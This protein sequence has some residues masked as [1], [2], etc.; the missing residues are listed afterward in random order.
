MKGYLSRHDFA[1]SYRAE[2]IRRVGSAAT[3]ARRAMQRTPQRPR[4]R[5]LLPI[6]DA[7]AWLVSVAMFAILR[8]DG[9]LGAVP[10]QSV[11]IA[12]ALLAAV[13]IAIAIGL[14][15]YDGRHA[16]G[17][18]DESLLL[19]LICAF[20]GLSATGILAFSTSRPV[21]L[22]LPLPATATA[23][24][25]IVGARVG[26]RLYRDRNRHADDDHRT[27]IVGAG[28]AGIQL[29]KSLLVDRRSSYDPICFVDDNPRKRHFRVGSVRVEGTL[30]DLPRLLEER[31]ID[32]IIIAA[33]SAGPALIRRVSAIAAEAGTKA[34]ALPTLSELA[35]RDDIGVSDLRDLEL[36]DFLRRE[37]VQTDLCQVSALLRGKRVLVTGAGGSIGS[38]LCRQIAQ[39]SPAQLYMLDRDES[40][41]HALQL[42]LDGR[43]LLQ[44]PG[45]VLADIRDYERIEQ[46]FTTHK[47]HVVFHA[48]AL[49]HLTMLQRYPEE[50][51][52]TNVIGTDNVLRA[53]RTSGAEIFVNISTDKAADPTSV[54]GDTKRAAERLTAA[55]AH[56][57]GRRYLSVRFGNVLGSRGS[58]LTAFAEQIRQGGPVTVTHPDVTRFF[59]TVQEAVQLV[60][61]AAALGKPADTLI[62]DMGAPVRILDVAHQMIAMSGR[63]VEIEFTGLRP[64]EKLHEDLEGS[65][66]LLV[67]TD[68][69]LI[70]RTRVEPL[71]PAVVDRI[72]ISSTGTLALDLAEASVSLPEQARGVPGLAP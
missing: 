72:A 35:G 15:L 30:D 27:V 10:W 41:L 1:R 23:I 62:L 66:E 36:S 6:F 61:Q 46:I 5:W 67:G 51:L 59:M 64:G 9:D 32:R 24:L 54:L 48:A 42:S 17:S 3:R 44:D 11:W 69:P 39:F 68:H 25:L 55:V 34:K 43:G 31:R 33:P 71:D 50:G 22:S 19:V 12:T 63:S 70:S 45:L 56:D 57:S 38:E 13:F 37:P 47:P 4:P 49:K 52:K 53:A 8:F 20:V 65:K 28:D 60:L 58:V 40:A 16:V 18:L 14:H 26:Y 7:A 29:A 21:P 2:P